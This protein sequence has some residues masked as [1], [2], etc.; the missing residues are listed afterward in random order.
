MQLNTKTVLL[1]IAAALAST[2]AASP[3]SLLARQYEGPE[4]DC[5]SCDLLNPGPGNYVCVVPLLDICPM[6]L[7][8]CPYNKETHEECCC[9][10]TSRLAMRCKA[11]PKG[12][13][14]SC[15]VANCPFRFEESYL[16]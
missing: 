11:V 13:E 14:C 6:P 12:S 2:A 16:P 1:A 9:C 7:I 4:A 5:C 15:P 8:A 3:A 10:D